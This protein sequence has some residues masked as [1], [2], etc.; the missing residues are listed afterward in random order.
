MPA[1]Y[2]LLKFAKEHNDDPFMLETIRAV[3][4]E[5]IPMPLCGVW[6]VVEN[7]R[8]DDMSRRRSVAELVQ[9]LQ[10]LRPER[11]EDPYTDRRNRYV[12]GYSFEYSALVARLSLYDEPDYYWD[13]V[14]VD[15]ETAEAWTA[16]YMRIEI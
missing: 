8:L 1:L 2:Q 6:W 4:S 7:H 13:R 12:C 10:R 11:F 3:I 14:I 9:E 16:E 15:S 5:R